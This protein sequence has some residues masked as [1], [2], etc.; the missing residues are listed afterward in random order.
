MTAPSREVFNPLQPPKIVLAAI[1]ITNAGTVSQLGI[2][3]L[4]KSVHPATIDSSTAPAKIP[5]LKR[6][7][8]CAGTWAAVPDCTHDI[9]KG[10]F[11]DGFKMPGEG[12]CPSSS[13]P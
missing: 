1:P 8:S 10:S 11:C 13:L 9:E 2:L 5:V 3:R 12:D 6:T 7:S 4:R